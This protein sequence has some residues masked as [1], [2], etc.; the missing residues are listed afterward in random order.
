M[1]SM[2]VFTRKC[3][4]PDV[5]LIACTKHASADTLIHRHKDNLLDFYTDKTKHHLQTN[6]L[7]LNATWSS[8]NWENNLQLSSDIERDITQFDTDLLQPNW[9]SFRRKYWSK[10]PTDVNNFGTRPTTYYANI[11]SSEFW[12]EYFVLWEKVDLVLWSPV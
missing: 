2:H 5:L 6:S 11:C 4:S 12:P 8:Y 3:G 7:G 9:N 1:S 10:I